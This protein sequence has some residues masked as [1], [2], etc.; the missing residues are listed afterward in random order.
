MGLSLLAKRGER[1]TE[2]DLC[3][4]LEYLLTTVVIEDGVDTAE[5]LEFFW[6]PHLANRFLYICCLPTP[7]LISFCRDHLAGE[8]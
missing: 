2:H 5:R 6:I 1:G 3:E 4:G 8:I 7:A